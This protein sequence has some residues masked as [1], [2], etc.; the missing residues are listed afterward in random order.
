MRIPPSLRLVLKKRSVQHRK[1]KNVISEGPTL[2]ISE[3][4][5]TTNTVTN[6]FGNSKTCDQR[7]EDEKDVLNTRP[8]SSTL[9][10]TA[11]PDIRDSKIE[12]TSEAAGNDVY[13]VH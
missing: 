6:A 4:P 7:V 8:V 9:P 2:H 13:T 3:T 5:N 11:V 12:E 1:K 10:P